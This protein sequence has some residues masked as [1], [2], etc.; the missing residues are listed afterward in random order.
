M[1]DRDSFQKIFSSFNAGVE[2]RIS[3]GLMNDPWGRF[4]K[5]NALI[6]LSWHLQCWERLFVSVAT[7]DRS[8]L[9]TRCVPTANTLNRLDIY[10]LGERVP[11]VK[12]DPHRVLP[13]PVFI[14]LFNNSL[15]CRFDAIQFVMS[16]SQV[17]GMTLIMGLPDSHAWLN[18]IWA[19]PR[20]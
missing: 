10:G 12:G 18:D 17:V 13:S 11:K 20:A 8:Y 14:R 6:K 19:D 4:I 7:A 5:R 3:I 1:T 15:A 16:S 2:T 9:I